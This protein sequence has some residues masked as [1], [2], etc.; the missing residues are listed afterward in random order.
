MLY[1]ASLTTGRLQLV[2]RVLNECIDLF[3]PTEKAN[4]AKPPLVER[5]AAFFLVL[6]HRDLANSLG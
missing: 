1:P 3:S 6:K 5:A 4:F 2:V